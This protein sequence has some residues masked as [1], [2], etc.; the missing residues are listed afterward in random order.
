MKNREEL[1]KEIITLVSNAKTGK[2][3]ELL[4]KEE[5][6]HLGKEV[7]IVSSRYSK[8]MKQKNLGV[9]PDEQYLINLNK[10]N[11]SLIDLA[12]RLDKVPTTPPV[13]ETPTPIIEEKEV[14]VQKQKVVTKT[15]ANTA[16]QSAPAKSNLTK[17]LL[18]GG[19][20]LLLSLGGIW[21]VMSSQKNAK[22]AKAEKAKQE[23]EARKQKQEAEA[24][25]KKAAAAAERKKKIKLGNSFE[26]GKIFYIDKTGQH[27]LIMALADRT[28]QKIKWSDQPR[29][30][31]E[32][33][34]TGIYKGMENTKLLAEKF[35]DGHPA[36][37][38]AD[39]KRGEYD[40]WYLPSREELDLL[41]E[42]T[43]NQND[44]KRN[45]KVINHK[46]FTHD[47]Y[48]SSTEVSG[49]DVYYRS[50]YRNGFSETIE[51][52]KPT[53]GKVRPIRK[54]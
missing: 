35:G 47:Y 14:P 38:C 8:L 22:K 27:G 2:A 40:D 48:W 12:E 41:W 6:P 34:E 25:A 31:A 29:V 7:I 17:Y 21:G 46:G 53:M 18:I 4:E 43:A 37:L 52:N 1:K 51:W 39:Y 5:L 32:A 10:I 13:E 20:L 15:V 26:G 45:A 28:P 44:L 9:M 33:Y 3:I 24:N 11:V 19:A 42:F 36:K 16:T 30:K 50:F 49:K 54:F 23:Q